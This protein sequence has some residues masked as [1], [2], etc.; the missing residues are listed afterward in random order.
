[1]QREEE[2]E[3][4]PENIA[5][6]ESMCTMSIETRQDQAHLD[7][8]RK[9]EISSCDMPM[10]GGDAVDLDEWYVYRIIVDWGEGVEGMRRKFQFGWRGSS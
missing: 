5:R 3:T 2:N 1:M 8:H 10:F 7:L 4:R 9:C 6:F